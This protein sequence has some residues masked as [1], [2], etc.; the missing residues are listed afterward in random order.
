MSSP[1][2]VAF[3]CETTG[4]L[5]GARLIEIGAVCFRDDGRVEAEFQEFVQPPVALPAF[6]TRLTGITP[7]MLCSADDA[8]SVLTRF[9]RWA[10]DRGIFVA[11]DVA[12]DLAVMAN[13]LGGILNLNVTFVDSLDIA[14]RLGEFSEIG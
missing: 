11:H 14:R 4:Y 9:L 1:L 5:P 8:T 3:D 13:E 6:I 12:F 10:P 7:W 2:W